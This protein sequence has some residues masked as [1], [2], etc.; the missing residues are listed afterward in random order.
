MI[1]IDKIF[2][3]KNV[4]NLI[5]QLKTRSFELPNWNSRL[6]KEYE[7]T[8]HEIVDDKIGRPD[9]PRGNGK[10]DKAARLPI[11]LEKLL[12]RRM[13]EFTCA[14]PVTRVYSYDNNDEVLKQIVT[15][16]E[17]IYQVAHINAENMHRAIC[18]YASCEMFTLWY[19]K[20]SPNKLYGFDSQYKLRCQTFS[21]MDGVRIYPLFDEYED[22]LALSFEYDRKVNDTTF[23]YFETFTAT[24]H[25]KWSMDGSEEANGWSSVIDGEEIAIEKIPASY[26]FRRQPCWEGLKPLRENIEYTLSRNSDVIAYNSAPILKVAGAIVGEEHKGETRRVYRVMENGDVSYVSWQQAIEALKYHVDTLLKLYFMQ[27]Q[28]PDISFEN[29][30]TLGNI[31][32]DSRKT[33]LMD[34]HLKIGEE[35]GKWIEFFEREANIIKAFLAKMNIKWA[36][37]LD[38]ISIEHVITPYVQ[39]DTNTKV[40]L[41]LKANGNKP[42]VSQKEAIKRAGLSDDPEATYLELQSEDNAEAERSAMNMSN[43]FTQE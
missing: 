28:M 41:W 12:T 18:Y 8:L 5:G 6:L 4:G 29:M 10:I 1:D 34:A 27:S 22:L 19:T 21:P 24:K 33:L 23:S 38:E 36:N 35:S 13:A 26:I 15:A 39:E 43:M 30:K 42:L 9:K 37:R 3:E 16:L 7:P 11:G 32:Y 14:I 40:D 31:G 2:E 17:K 25:Y 20:K